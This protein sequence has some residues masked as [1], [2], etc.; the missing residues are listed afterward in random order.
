MTNEMLIMQAREH[1]EKIVALTDTLYGRKRAAKTLV[2]AE[3]DKLVAH[4]RLTHCAATE[5]AARS[6]GQPQPPARPD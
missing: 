6:H 3:C 2:A 1:A 4:A 5:L